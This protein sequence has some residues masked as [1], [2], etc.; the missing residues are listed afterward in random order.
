MIDDEFDEQMDMQSFF[1]RIQS[2]SEMNAERLKRLSEQPVHSLKSSEIFELI[3]NKMKLAALV[4][5]AL[6][7]IEKKDF[8]DIKNPYQTP[9]SILDCCDAFFK[10][11][12]I[13]KNRYDKLKRWENNRGKCPHPKTKEPRE[14]FP[15]ESSA[16]Q[17]AEDLSDSYSDRMIPHKCDNCG[18]WHVISEK[19][20]TPSTECKY[21]QK[22]LYETKEA[23][24]KRAQIIRNEKGRELKVYQC[25]HQHGWH[26]TSRV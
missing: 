6:D 20:H 9:F 14:G 5:L 4:P 8:I 15:N 25:E 19:R 2:Q 1:P 22:Q 10:T 11:N 12:S 17:Y 24:S 16:Q 23:A 3:N 26:L 13:Q 21:C 7:L 18:E